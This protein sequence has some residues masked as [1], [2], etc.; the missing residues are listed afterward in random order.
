MPSKVIG[1][2]GGIASGKSTAAEH[3]KR[4]GAWVLDAD[5]VSRRVVERGT[6]GHAAILRAFGEEFFTE[7]GELD[8]KKLGRHVF[9]RPGE[10]EKLNDILHPLILEA[11]RGDVRAARDAGEKLIVVVMPLLLECG[12]QHLVDEVW[13]ISVSED[14]QVRRL[15]QRDAFTRE[16]ALRR[17]RAQ[18]P[19]EER[20]KQSHR[21]IDNSGDAAAM[22]RELDR[23]LKEEYA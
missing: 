15:M 3:L 14:M 18:M 23:L 5:E 8:R 20:R 21:I 6:A 4:R 11:I 13:S 9:A 12:A 10:L 7:S 2:T 22:L 19:E 16:E 1:L 17:I